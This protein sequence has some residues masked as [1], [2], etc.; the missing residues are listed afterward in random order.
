[1]CGL[2]GIFQWE[3]WWRSVLI[4]EWKSCPVPLRLVSIISPILLSPPSFLHKSWCTV[5][6][7]QH[8]V[9]TRCP[10]LINW[11][12][13]VGQQ[14]RWRVLQSLLQL[15]GIVWHFKSESVAIIPSTAPGTGCLWIIYFTVCYKVGSVTDMCTEKKIN[16]YWSAKSPS[17]TDSVELQSGNFQK[18]WGCLVDDSK[19]TGMSWNLFTLLHSQ[20]TEN[21]F[22]VTPSSY[23]EPFIKSPESQTFSDNT[24]VSINRMKMKECWQV[25]RLYIGSVVRVLGDRHICGFW[26]VVN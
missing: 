26:Y 5:S 23:L 11:L 15:K 10:P 12:V 20:S 22:W 17:M 25:K 9:N 24:F 13:N 21:D 8:S 3:R 16:C 4:M 1:M 2:N 6:T 14:L 19:E 18:L 7:C